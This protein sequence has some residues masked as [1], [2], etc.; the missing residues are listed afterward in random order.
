[1]K[2]NINKKFDDDYPWLGMDTKA[3][4]QDLLRHYHL[5]LG[6]EQAVCGESYVYQASALTIRD[7]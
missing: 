1:M 7:R 5:T 6:R 4:K 3:V 2:C